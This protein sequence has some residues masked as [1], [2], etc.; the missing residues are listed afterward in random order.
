MLDLGSGGTDEGAPRR[1]ARGGDHGRGRRA[2]RAGGWRAVQHDAQAWAARGGEGRAASCPSRPAEVGLATCAA[3]RADAVR[4][5]VLAPGGTGVRQRRSRASRR[6][7]AWS[8]RQRRVAATIMV[9]HARERGEEET[10][11]WTT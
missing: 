4:G 10:M 7:M 2:G 9:A 8:E 3:S 11:P 5:G 1:A 6:G